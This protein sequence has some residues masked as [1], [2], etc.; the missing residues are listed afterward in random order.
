MLSFSTFVIEETEPQGKKL[1]HLTHLE[2]H[3]IHNGHEGIGVAAQHLDDVHNLLSGKKSSTTVSTKYDGSPSIVFGT[4]PETGKF[5]VAS[6]SAFNKN[7]KINYTP[8]DIEA[9][10]GHAPGLVE[11]L[12]SALEHLPKIMPKNGGVFQGDM[13]YT[14]PDIEKKNG[15]YS[16]TPNTITYSTPK[17][18]QHGTAIKNSQMGVVVHTKYNGKNLENMSADALDPKTRAS[19][20]THGDVHNIDP[21]IDA[22]PSNYTPE[23]RMAFANHRENAR[24]AYAKLKPE[25]ADALAGHGPDLEGHVNKMVREGG[26]PSLEGYLEHLKTKAQ[27]DIDGVKTPAAKE[28]K[29]Q[30]HSAVMDQVIKDQDHFKKALELHGHLQAAKDVLTNVMAKNNPF[31]H[32]IGGETTGP[33][34]AVAVDKKGNMSKFVDRQEFSRQNFLKGKQ[35][36]QKAQKLSEEA[37]SNHVITFMRAN[38]F[39][40]GHLTVARKVLDLAKKNNATHSII[41]SH[42]QDAAKNPLSPEQKLKYAKKAVPGANILTSSSEAPTML[43]HAVNAY[44][45]GAKHLHVVVG[46]DRVPEFEKLLNAYNGKQSRHGMYNFKSITVHSAGNRDPDAEGTVGISGTKMRDAA[47]GGD[48]NVFHAG[49]ASTLS[50]TDKNNMMKDVRNGMGLKEENTTASIGGLGFNSGNPAVTDQEMLNYMNNRIADAD[51]RDNILK[52]MS[53]KT[54]HHK[55]HKAIGFKSFLMDKSKDK[56]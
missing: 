9:N 24:R 50:T 23:E 36:Q 21:T 17:D 47:K 7:P 13:M 1:K 8:E 14:K 42:S 4:H 35:S 55:T 37:E 18:S 15:M 30:A 2:D 28:R 26:Q 40:E 51:T 32:S 11:K 3:V 54:F 38:P 29:A 49:A 6:K 31:M 19:F 41:L 12:K 43:H 27:K 10:H 20:K 25:A 33:E 16:F 39:T 45:S 48:K 52:A 46:E 53:D 5:F 44:N 56:K 34:G 22:N